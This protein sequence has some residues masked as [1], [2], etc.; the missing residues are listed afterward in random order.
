[1]FLGICMYMILIAQAAAMLAR[2]RIV[3]GVCEGPMLVKKKVLIAK[4][5]VLLFLLFY[6]F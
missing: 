3:V 5:V 2:D 1:M 6:L 4:I